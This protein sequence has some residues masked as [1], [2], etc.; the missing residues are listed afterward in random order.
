MTAGHSIPLDPDRNLALELG[1]NAL[2]ERQFFG[3]GFKYECCVLHSRRQPV[4]RA[5]A[6]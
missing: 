1:K 5:D 3:R 4:V 6:P 2:L